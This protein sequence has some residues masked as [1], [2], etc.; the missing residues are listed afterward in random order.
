M[1]V[2]YSSL[3][4]IKF[5]PEFKEEAEK[6]ARARGKSLSAYIRDLIVNDIKRK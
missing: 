6:A 3:V 5:I 4:T 1:G 2:T